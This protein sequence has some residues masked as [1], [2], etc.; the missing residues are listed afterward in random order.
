M[1]IC[2]KYSYIKKN[3]VFMRLCELRQKEIINTCTCK[4][5]GCPVDLEFDAEAMFKSFAKALDQAVS[6]DPRI[7]DVLSTKGSLA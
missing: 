2:K 4:S 1:Y 3:G 7:T 6:F 5:L